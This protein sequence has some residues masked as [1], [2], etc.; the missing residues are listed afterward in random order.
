MKQIF[1]LTV[2]LFIAVNSFAQNVIDNHFQYLVEDKNSTNIS[3]SGKMFQLIN[4]IDI[5][6]DGNE[7]LEEMQEFIGSITGFQM[8][9]G[10][11]MTTARSQYDRGLQLV[12]GDYDELLSVVDKEG[13]FKLYV[14]ENKDIVREVVGIG[15]SEEMLMVFSFSGDMRLDQVG[16][17]IEHIQSNDFTQNIDLKDMDPDKV[18]VYPN[19]ATAN[20]ILEL[21]IPAAMQGSTAKLYDTQGNLVKSYQV[22]NLTESI[23]LSGTSAGNYVLKLEKDGIRVS[24]KI[25]IIE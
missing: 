17:V 16:K 13:H 14:D 25:V 8:V 11:E 19:P 10:K 4:S 15:T 9:V 1:L 20:S 12:D 21:E 24:K 5:E 2:S 7:E 23:E 18:S 3:V 22:E 6:T